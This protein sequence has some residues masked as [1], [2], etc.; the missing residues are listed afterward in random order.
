MVMEILWG[1]GVFNMD[2]GAELTMVNADIIV[3]KSDVGGGSV[4]CGVDGIATVELFKESSEG[5]RPMGPE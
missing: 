4:P 1:V 3:Q 5:V 2:R